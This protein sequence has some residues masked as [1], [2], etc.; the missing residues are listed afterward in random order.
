MQGIMEKRPTDLTRVLEALKK[1]DKDVHAN[2]IIGLGL[3]RWMED[4]L[5]DARVEILLY[6]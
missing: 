5:D 1:A 4:C 3:K 2:C 6:R